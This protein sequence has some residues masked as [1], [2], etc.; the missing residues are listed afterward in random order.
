[1]FR[2]GEGLN[3]MESYYMNLTSDFVFF[4]ETSIS[5]SSDITSKDS[6]EQLAS[7]KITN[8]LRI[9]DGLEWRISESLLSAFF[10]LSRVYHS[11][12]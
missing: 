10:S 6:Q 2:N 4:L 12:A 7:K 3:L 1:M 8:R 9:L 11:E 5:V